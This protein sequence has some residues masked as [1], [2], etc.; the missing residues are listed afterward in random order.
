[1]SI[2]N[3]RIEIATAYPNLEEISVGKGKGMTLR[4]DIQT[5]QGVKLAFVKLLSLEGIAREAICSVLAR[6]LQLPVRQGYYVSLLSTQF[7]GKAG[8]I[9]SLAFGTLHDFTR[10]FRLK[11]LS[12][13]EAELLKWPDLLNSAVFDEWIANGDR[14]PNNMAF[15]RGGVFWLF[16][17]D[18]AFPGHVS[19]GTPVN[20]QLLALLAKEKAEFELYQIRNKALDIVKSYEQ[21][22]WDEIHTW[23]RATEFKYL[24]QYFVKQIK[25][26]RAR[27]PEMR[28]ILTQDLGIKQTELLFSDSQKQPKNQNHE[29]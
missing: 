19:A 11:E 22:N 12:G 26:L 28:N 21:V 10:L 7:H 5:D 16:D 3:P 15:E 27:I 29:N 2:N 8:N 13:F 23:V 14:L 4:G 18:E 6:K 20:S 9:E 25:F 17:H 24:E 1:M